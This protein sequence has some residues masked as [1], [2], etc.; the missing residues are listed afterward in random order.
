VF[1]PDGHLVRQYASTEPARDTLRKNIA[2]YWLEPPIVLATTPGMHR[3]AW[4][5]RYPA[6][7]VI[8][9]GYFGDVLPYREY[10]LTVH[11][12]KGKTP[13][14]Q[15]TGPLVAPGTYRVRLD[16][17]GQTY[18]R[19][20]VVKNDPRIT[21]TQAAL[22]AQERLQLRMMAGLEVSYAAFEHLQRTKTALASLSSTKDTVVAVAAHTLEQ[23]VDALMSSADS[24]FGPA[25]RELTRLL[26]DMESGDI[27][28]TPSTVSAVDADCRKLDAALAAMADIEKALAAAHVATL[29]D[30]RQFA[31][32]ACGP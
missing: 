8:N 25:N 9:Y 30:H 5:L 1:D 13:R 15:P 21:V 3:L 14:V 27:D 20:L 17:G 31:G 6:P 11:A 19:E 16:V 2:D 23:R 4:D 32:P 29:A 10:T 26:E 12:V 7:R 18:E 24:G 22:V 28:P